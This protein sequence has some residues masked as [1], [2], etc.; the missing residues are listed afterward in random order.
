MACRVGITT[1]P[2]KRNNI[3]NKTCPS[4]KM[5]QGASLRLGAPGDAVQVSDKDAHI[6]CGK[7]EGL[8]W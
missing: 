6:G 4:S 7:G 3:I 5:T 1:D 2:E 8:R